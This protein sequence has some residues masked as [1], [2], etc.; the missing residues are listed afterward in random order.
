MSDVRFT[1]KMKGGSDVV[2]LLNRYPEKI[3]SNM[4]AFR[5][6]AYLTEA[7]CFSS[8]P[9][10]EIGGIMIFYHRWHGWAQMV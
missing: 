3:L 5:S 4:P 10:S 7:I 9:V 6:N 2:R 1:A 8:V